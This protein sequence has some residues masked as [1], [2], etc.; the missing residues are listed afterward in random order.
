MMAKQKRKR[1]MKRLPVIPPLFD[2]GP[3]GPTTR[4]IAL[5]VREH[6]AASLDQ[7][8]RRA[9]AAGSFCWRSSIFSTRRRMLGFRSS[10]MLNLR[11]LQRHLR[12]RVDLHA[13][14][15]ARHRC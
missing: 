3:T 13:M 2:L 4:T 7:A 11:S 5:Q 14:L 8:Q 1:P 15:H 12:V 10:L 9:Y 6:G